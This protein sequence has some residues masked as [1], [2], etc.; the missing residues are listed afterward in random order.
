MNSAYSFH[1]S[2]IFRLSLGIRRGGKYRPRQNG[3][4]L[5]LHGEHIFRQR[6]WRLPAKGDLV[7]FLDSTS[8]QPAEMDYSAALASA[9][10]WLG[11][12]YLLARPVKKL[13]HLERCDPDLTPA[14]RDPAS[15]SASRP[16]W[17]RE[18]INHGDDACQNRPTHS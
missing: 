18:L 3:N 17:L 5:P 6:T 8:D 11:N 7:R 1:M 2:P 13:T 15:S 16:L 9:V 14:P 4:I 12:R 10:A